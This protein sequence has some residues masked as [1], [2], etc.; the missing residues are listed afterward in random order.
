ME[1]ETVHFHCAS[2][3][4][5]ASLFHGKLNILHIPVVTFQAGGNLL[6]WAKSSAFSSSRLLIGKGVEYRN[7]SSPWAFIKNSP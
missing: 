1:G 6:N 5:T 3:G 7:T 4:C 2:A